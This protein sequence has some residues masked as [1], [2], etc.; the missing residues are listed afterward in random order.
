MGRPCT[1]L[2]P[3]YVLPY[4]GHN[5]IDGLQGG[6]NKATHHKVTIPFEETICSSSNRLLHRCPSSRA[7]RRLHSVGGGAPVIFARRRRRAADQKKS[8]AAAARRGVVGA[9]DGS[10]SL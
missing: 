10:K 5:G 1:E 3:I 8:A 7:L 4:E 6:G 2:A 9:S